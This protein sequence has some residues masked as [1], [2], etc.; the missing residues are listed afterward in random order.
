MN[1]SRLAGND[2]ICA[3][4]GLRLEYLKEA[5]GGLTEKQVNILADN[6]IEYLKEHLNKDCFVSVVEEGGEI[7]SCAYMNLFRKAANLRFVNGLYAEIYGVYTAKEFRNR[8][9]A[10]KNVETL[11]EYGRQ[12][13]ASFVELDA[14]AE[15]LGVY[16]RIGFTEV[17]S[18]YTKM[19]YFYN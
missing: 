6:N 13:G 3:V 11:V 15:G 2:E 19:K 7:V 5:Y 18:E 14:S 1:R 10:T 8:S 12:T 9:F 4:T 16:R 17:N